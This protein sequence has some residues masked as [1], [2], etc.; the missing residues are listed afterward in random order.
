[1]ITERVSVG[2]LNEEEE[3]LGSFFSLISFAL[4]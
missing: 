1:L 2:V 4:S 3:L